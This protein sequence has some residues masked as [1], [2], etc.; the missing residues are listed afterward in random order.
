[1]LSAVWQREPSKAKTR[2]AVDQSLTTLKGERF[3]KSKKFVKLTLLKI[4]EAIHQRR[5][6][7]K[8]PGA[9]GEL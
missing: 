1:M 7:T 8:N 9:V 3:D 5:N 6:Q 2:L 4:L